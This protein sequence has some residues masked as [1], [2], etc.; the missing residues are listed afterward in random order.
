[1][2][3][4]Y[5]D[6]TCIYCNRI[7]IPLSGSQKTCGAEA[8]KNKLHIN[9][10]SR[11]TKPK[12]KPTAKTVKNKNVC[13]GCKYHIEKCSFID[14]NGSCD[15]ENQTGRSRLKIELDNGGY[16]TDACICRVE[17]NR[18]ARNVQPIK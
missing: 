8:C 5:K 7:Y 2:E 12:E 10:N 11:R 9:Y 15:F 16:R 4:N 1:M 17:G 14:L 18:K 6:K 13:E 3:K